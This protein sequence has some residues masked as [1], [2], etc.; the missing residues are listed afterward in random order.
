MMHIEENI[1]IYIKTTES[2]KIY[3]T[4]VFVINVC[5]NYHV[6]QLCIFLNLFFN[7]FF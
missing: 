4:D 7:L 2:K 1:D 5:A 3:A 6:L